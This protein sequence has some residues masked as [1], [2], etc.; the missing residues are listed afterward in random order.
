M[1]GENETTARR[2]PKK[3][4]SM[5]ETQDANLQKTK[6]DERGVKGVGRSKKDEARR[7]KLTQ[8]KHDAVRYEGS[9]QGKDR[10]KEEDI[11]LRGMDSDEQTHMDTRSRLGEVR[12]RKSS[13]AGCMAEM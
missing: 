12:R 6:C 5:A 9:Y 10:E 1:D 8:I 4:V 2:F 11:R 3:V 7:C 13:S